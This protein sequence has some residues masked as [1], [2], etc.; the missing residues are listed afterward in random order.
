MV[1]SLPCQS[2]VLLSLFPWS[3]GRLDLACLPASSGLSSSSAYWL[4]VLWAC[5]PNILKSPAGISSG[6]SLPLML[7]RVGSSCPGMPN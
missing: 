6:W 2:R 1:L 4:L 5:L 7:S 3:P